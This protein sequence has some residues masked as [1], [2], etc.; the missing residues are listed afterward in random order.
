MTA[1]QEIQALLICAS[2]C[3]RDELERSMDD[4]ITRF[5]VREV[6]WALQDLLD[7]PSDSSRTL[8]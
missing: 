6:Y 8:H 1:R 5:G 7:E 4:L 2:H 3:T